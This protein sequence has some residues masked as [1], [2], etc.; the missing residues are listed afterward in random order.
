MDT[1]QR[2]HTNDEI[3]LVQFNWG[4]AYWDPRGDY[5]GI[6]SM[7]T[8]CGDGL[9][10]VWPT[11]WLESDY[12]AHA[13]GTSPLRISLTENGVGDFTAHIV[14]EAAV[15]G[16]KFAMVAVEDSY[17][18]ANGG[19][20]SHL[21]HHVKSF[22]T[23]VSGDAFELAAGESLDINKTFAIDPSWDY[24]DMGV[25]CWVQKPGGTN[26]SPAPLTVPVRNQVL[27]S[28]YI[29]AM[30]TS[31]AGPH[32]EARMALLAPSPN[33]FSDESQVSFV[34][35]E[36]GKASLEVFDVTGRRVAVLVD[37]VLPAG[38]HHASWDGRD[39]GGTDCSTGIYFARLVYQGSET[40][41]QKVAKM[42]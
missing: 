31:V 34:L 27:Q 8:I 28:A 18:S 39:S 13:A 29:D 1:W 42:H 14:A 21:V 20:T 25:A 4:D 16:A 7:P 17:V 23:A 30:S 5:Y 2:G 32:G 40:A 15:T 6:V 22:L 12:Q 3:T 10:D 19:G 26:P 37:A 11:S 24:E 41:Y 33:P 36:T 9:S 38:I 35:P